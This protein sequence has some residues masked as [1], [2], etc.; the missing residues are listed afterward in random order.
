MSHAAI[1]LYLREANTD[2]FLKALR[3]G[4]KECFVSQISD[5]DF[6]N[7]LQRLLKTKNSVNP[8]KKLRL[9]PFGM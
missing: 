3:L 9:F 1:F 5:E 8:A 7:A 2:T 4:V 6:Q